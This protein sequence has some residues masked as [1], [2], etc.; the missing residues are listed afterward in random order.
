MKLIYNPSGT[1]HAR[2]VLRIENRTAPRRH[3]TAGEKLKIVRAVD[4]VMASENLPLNVAATRHGVDPA[5]LCKWK[6]S[7]SFSSDD[8]VGRILTRDDEL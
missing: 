3:Y 4:A 7:G 1:N 5:C 6:K 2:E 8:S